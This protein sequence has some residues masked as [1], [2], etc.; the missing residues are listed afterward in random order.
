MFN[1]FMW[2]VLSAKNDN[3]N[4]Q[5]WPDRSGSAWCCCCLPTPMTLASG[6]V[7]SSRMW[8]TSQLLCPSG[9]QFRP[10]SGVC[11]DFQ[12]WQCGAY[13]GKVE[14]MM[15]L[16]MWVLQRAHCGDGCDLAS[17]LCKYDFREGDSFVLSWAS[18]RRVR[19]VSIS[20]ELQMCDGGVHSILLLPLVARCLE[21]I[22]V[23]IWRMFV[24]LICC[25]DC[26]WMFVV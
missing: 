14:E 19:R 25:R 24:F 3:F 10:S 6:G 4:S 26:V 22:D 12:G 16:C 5:V 15:M 9:H 13:V 2:N 7:R 17:T 18:V 21:I 1:A 20:S 8:S 23:C 11:P